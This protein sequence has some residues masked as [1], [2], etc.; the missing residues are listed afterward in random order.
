MDLVSTG[1]ITTTLNNPLTVNV[2]TDTSVVLTAD[3]GFNWGGSIGDYV[4]MDTNLNG[5]PD[6]TPAQPI[7]NAIVLLYYDANG[8][9]VLDPFADIQVGFART[10]A[11][12]IYLFDNLPPGDY[13]V[14]VYED[15]ITTDGNRDIVP[16]TRERPGRQPGSCPGA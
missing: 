4:W 5:L 14:D 12:G 1:G 13:L 16:T 10:D 2:P 9:G 7:A 6:E 15:S 3:F 8:D 11:N